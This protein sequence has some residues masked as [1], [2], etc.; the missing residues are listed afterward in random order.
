MVQEWSKC[1]CWTKEERARTEESKAEV[2]GQRKAERLKVAKEVC[3]VLC[4]SRNVSIPD[5][6]PDLT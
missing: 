6:S 2:S 5:G 4:T 3:L 1:S